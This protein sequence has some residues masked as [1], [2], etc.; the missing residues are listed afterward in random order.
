MFGSDNQAPAHP[1]V[2]EAVLEANQGHCGSYGDDPWT[3]RATKALYAAFETEDLDMYCVGTG[4]S[5]NGLALSVLCPPWAA[6]LAHPHAHILEDEG[7]GPEFFTSGARMVSLG[8]DGHLV[9]PEDLEQAASRHDPAFVHGIQ[10][11]VLTLTNLSEL[12]QVYRPDHLKSLHQVCARQGWRLHVDGARFANAVVASGA[13]AAEMSW[14]SG[15]D[16]LS[17]GLTKNGALAA[18]VLILFGAARSHAAPYLRK[19]AGQLFS[20]HRY[21]SAQIVAMLEDGLWLDLATSA[22]QTAQSLAKLLEGAGAELVVPVQGNE[23]FARLTEGHVKALRDA[24]IGFF[25]WNGLGPDTYRFVASWHNEAHCLDAVA[26]ALKRN[27]APN[28]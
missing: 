12:G 26:K 9:T 14:R 23:V 6:V 13:S 17:F 7:N 10:P 15:V 2:L 22:N 4:G 1:K 25:P 16:A 28:L 20:K 21:L 8:S 24:G 19:R 3:S 5:A 27:E 18:E 11:R